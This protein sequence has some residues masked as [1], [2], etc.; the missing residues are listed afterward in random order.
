[1]SLI[2][3]ECKTVQV[4]MSLLE[5]VF[6]CNKQKVFTFYKLKLIAAHSPIGVAFASHFPNRFK[7]HRFDHQAWHPQIYPTGIC[8]GTAWKIAHWK[9]THS[10][11]ML[12]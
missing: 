2:V 10:L 1:M 12:I 5:E 11:L 4:S 6:I 8:K 9:I 3:H 7:N